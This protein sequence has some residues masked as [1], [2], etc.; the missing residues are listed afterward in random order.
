M[1]P[2]FRDLLR[3]IALSPTWVA[4][5]AALL[6]TTMVAAHPLVSQER[7]GALSP[8]VRAILAPLDEEYQQDFRDDW[9]VVFR[10]RTR[11][12]V[13][14]PD[15]PDARA[16]QRELE[17]GRPNIV[18]ESLVIVPMEA[19]DDVLLALYNQLLAVSEFDTIEFFSERWQ[20]R[21]P[22]FNHSYR[23]A[24]IDQ[25]NPLPDFSVSAIPQE[26]TFYVDQNFPPM[27]DAVSEYELVW[28]ARTETLAFAAT[29]LEA[30]RWNNVPVIGDG[31]LNIRVLV[32]AVPEGLLI[33]GVG[34]VRAFDLGGLLY[35]RIA[36]PFNGRVAGILDW[37]YDTTMEVA[38]E[39]A[40]LT[41]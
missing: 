34:A 33:Y 32:T 28:D 41:R 6:L 26:L 19:R 36:V 4:M 12:L 40:A 37:V 27:T 35:D 11:R 16:M 39:Q 22:V 10:D 5:V 2:I 30:L 14:T 18:A 24:S 9:R 38:R 1:R 20:E 29:T 8:E 17:R 23:V 31:N 7:G 13:L 15:I 25:R 3:P 21:L